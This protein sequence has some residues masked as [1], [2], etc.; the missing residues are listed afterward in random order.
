MQG[1]STRDTGIAIAR[2]RFLHAGLAAGALA[3]APNVVRPAFAQSTRPAGRAEV[4]A[5]ELYHYLADWQRRE[6]CFPYESPLRAHVENNWH[7][8]PH[9]LAAFLTP[10]STDG[11]TWLR[12]IY[13]EAIAREYRLFSYGDAMLI[14]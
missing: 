5:E 4:L 7:I 6:L 12:E 14:L 13:S 11:I 3:V 9:T 2:R 1:A 8:V 10:D